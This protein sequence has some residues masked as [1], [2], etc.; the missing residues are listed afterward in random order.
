MILVHIVT[1]NRPLAIEIIDKLLE[2]KLLFNAMMSRKRVFEK[3]IV[4]G[5]LTNCIH[6][7]IIGKT[8]SL[9]FSKINKI[10]LENYG[11]SDQMPS[12]YCLPI[13]YMDPQRA[14]AL[15]DHTTEV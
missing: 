10:L 5:E 12:L 11:A 13:V 7:L 8:K 4:T 6:T 9:L 3:D 2:E 1:K 14:E 15:L